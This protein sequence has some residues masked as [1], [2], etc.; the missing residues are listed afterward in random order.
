MEALERIDTGEAGELLQALA[1]GAPEAWLTC[2]AKAAV[3][4]RPA[5]PATP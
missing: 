4:R 2:D 5:R 1:G 3:E